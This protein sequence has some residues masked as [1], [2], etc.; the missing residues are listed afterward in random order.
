MGRLDDKVCVVTGASSGIG[1]RTAELFA[2]EGAKVAM[3]AR[4]GKEMEAIAK[5]IRAKGGE[6]IVLP[7]DIREVEQVEAAIAKTIETYGRIDGLANV[8][9][10]LDVAMRPID[11]FLGEDLDKTL[12]T[13][14]RGTMQVTR[15][16]VKHFVEN[17]HG[18]IATVASMAGYNG[19]GSAAYV[20]SKG[21][22]V[23]LTKHIAMEFACPG[24]VIRAN[25]ICPG[26]VWTP[27]AQRAKKAWKT[28]G[29]AAKRFNESIQKHTCMEVKICRPDDI[30]NLLLFLISDESACLTGQI[31]VA[32]FGC[33]L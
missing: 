29:E 21:A 27:M 8:A 22:L 15:A 13:N 5:K 28:Y 17:G 19:N 25:A 1:A 18:T 2:A 12:N 26:S 30:A 32:D 3:L 20:A 9:G 6:A 7:T 11:D 16:C 24:P 23:S 10:Y 14:V 33:N 4:R 31:L